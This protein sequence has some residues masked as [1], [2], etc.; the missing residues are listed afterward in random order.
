MRHSAE[1][2][3]LGRRGL[4]RAV[5]GLVCALSWL[6]GPGSPALAQSDQPIVCQR[7]GLVD[8]ESNIDLFVRDRVGELSWI[9]VAGLA[10]WPEGWPLD[11]TLRGRVADWARSGGLCVAP[12]LVP[13]AADGIA[14]RQVWLPDDRGSLAVLMAREGWGQVAGNVEQVVPA[15]M[16]NEL[17]AAEADARTARRGLWQIRT[18]LVDY[19][20]PSGLVLRTDSRLIPALDVMA[21][22]EISR[23]LLDSLA[24]A[25]VPIFPAPPVPGAWAFYDPRGRVIQVSDRLVG[26]DPRSAAV[27]I[28]HEATHAQDHLEGRLRL[29]RHQPADEAACFASETRAFGIEQNLWR[30][31]YGPLGRPIELHALDR[32]QNV[33]MEFVGE[34]AADLEDLIRRAYRRLCVY[35]VDY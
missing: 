14:L 30:Q 5:L 21:S 15:A 7:V 16:A 12:A 6:A 8:A 33:L 26:I 1:M 20:T 22:S 25:D 11:D 29:E 24:R 27:V 18:A 32:D 4:L 34:S 23:P 28:A 10:R 31:L 13:T 19:R 3:H 9:R 35:Y 2:N 17:R